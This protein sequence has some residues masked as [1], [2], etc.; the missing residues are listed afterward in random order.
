MSRSSAFKNLFSIVIVFA[1]VSAAKADCDPA[2]ALSYFK[3]AENA[4]DAQNYGGATAYASSSAEMFGN[5]VDVT[6]GDH[7]RLS[8]I[9]KANGLLLAARASNHFDREGAVR[10]AQTARDTATIVIYGSGS[11]QD[12]KNEASSI[13]SDAKAIIDGP[14]DEPTMPDF[15]MPPDDAT[16]PPSFIPTRRSQREPIA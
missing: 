16:P 14:S 9:M 4:M 10:Y 1:T 3:Q 2:Q 13:A 6:T 7:H 11:T 5:C 15:T 12:E 8:L